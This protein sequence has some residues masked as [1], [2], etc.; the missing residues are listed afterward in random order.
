M[1]R[2]YTWRQITEMGFQV[3]DYDFPTEPGNCKRNTRE[4]TVGKQ[5]PR[6][7]F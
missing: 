3:T 2:A 7:L 4:E 1:R 5:Q 6:L